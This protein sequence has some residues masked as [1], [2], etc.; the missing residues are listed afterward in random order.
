VSIV[1]RD[2]K[3][4]AAGCSLSDLFPPYFIKLCQNINP[5]TPLKYDF[6]I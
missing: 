5:K 4:M 1:L 6:S 3:P 2:L